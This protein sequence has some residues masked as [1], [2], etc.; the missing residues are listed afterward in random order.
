MPQS[1]TRKDL[2]QMNRWGRE[3]TTA[4]NA[5]APNEP[6]KRRI[7]AP[8]IEKPAEYLAMT[9]SNDEYSSLFIEFEEGVRNTADNT[10]DTREIMHALRERAAT[11]SARP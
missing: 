3:A 7:S 9:S 4:F 10:Y 6:W 11:I 5:T 8:S 1:A 2:L